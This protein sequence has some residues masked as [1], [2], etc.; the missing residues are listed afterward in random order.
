MSLHQQNIARIIANGSNDPQDLSYRS[1]SAA[2]AKYFA[3]ILELELCENAHA[4]NGV[5]DLTWKHDQCVILMNLIKSLT[6]DP[7]Y[8]NGYE[9]V[10]GMW[11]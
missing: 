5:C 4:N 7:K 9:L 3:D 11:D 1:E 10:L 8:D 2:I 6:N